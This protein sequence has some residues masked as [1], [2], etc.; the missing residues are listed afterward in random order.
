[1]HSPTSLSHQ[2]I[3]LYSQKMLVIII[4]VLNGIKAI[5]PILLLSRTLIGSCDNP[6]GSNTL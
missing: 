3:K 1:M 4:P 6:K 2:S 5:F